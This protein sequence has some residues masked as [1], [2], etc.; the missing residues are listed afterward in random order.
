MSSLPALA[1]VLLG[2]T[3]GSTPQINPFPRPPLPEAALAEWKFD[4]GTEG[5]TPEHACRIS[6]ADGLL[7]VR[8]TGEDPY[9]HRPASLPGGDLVLRIRARSRT[10]G[11]GEIFW[12]TD[13]SPVRG[14]DKSR[15]FPLN[16][17]GRWHE[18]AVEFSAPGTLTDL[19]LDPGGGAGEFDI[20]WIRLARRRWH[21]LG[22]ERV[23][24]TPHAVRLAVKNYETSPCTITA[25]GRSYT[26]AGGATVAVERPV[27]GGSPLEV[28]GTEI[29]LQ[30][31]GIP[32]AEREKLPPLRRTVFL[33]HPEAAADWI[34]VPAG[35]CVLEVARDGSAARV[36]RGSQ[37]VAGLAPL[38]HCDGMV[39]RLSLV[40]QEPPV[41]F[42][43]AGIAVEIAVHGREFTV[44]IASAQPCEGPVV[45]VLGALKQGLFAGVEYLGAGEASSSKLD[46]ETDEHI[47]FAPDPL[48]V[49]MPLMGFVADRA[50]VAMTW[51]DMS[52]QPVYATPNF[53][54]G[55]GDH[56]MALRGKKIEATI[57][58]DRLP[59]EEVIAWAV[60]RH[61]LPPLPPAP[62][63]PDEQRQICLKALNGPLKS[64]A[65]WGHCA[66]PNWARHPYDGMASTIWRLESATS[67][68]GFLGATIPELPR[69]VPGGVHV[70]NES[71]YFVTGRAAQWKQLHV[72]QV[73]ALIRQQQPDASYR[74]DGPF[75]RGH[76]ENT[77]SGICAGPAMHLLE[78]A[79][80]TGDREALAAGCRTLDYM[81]RFDV[82]R[83]AQTWE[84][85]LHTPDLLA[86]AYSVW[87]YV[88]GYEVTGKKEYL[89]EARRWALSGIPF[90]Y[91]WSRYPI[92]LYSTPP[93][94]GATNWQYNWIGLPVQWVGG[95]YAYALTL[96]AP[97]DHSLDWSHLARGI[98]ISAEQQQYPDG[99]WVGLLPDSFVIR[100][101]TR[102]PARI[103]PCAIA[104][105]RMV[106]DG[107]LDSLAVAAAGK[108]RVAAP[109]P[110]TIRGGKAHVQAPAG[111]KYQ[112]LVDG[113]V[114]EVPAE[115]NGMVPL[116]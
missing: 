107:Q 67:G 9:F 29:R 18:Y 108:H 101:Q 103:N 52:L 97:H 79:W 68:R 37:V 8:N 47:R 110:V 73:Q 100:T 19:R 116:D 81:K 15:A 84:V 39:P 36:R 40:H 112:V 62:R 93:V 5:W 114:V 99:P 76:F 85:P 51:N 111:L 24:T 75:R 58:V 64:E 115:A 33:F 12:T 46:I 69:L 102:N 92:M 35:D 23:E 82:P 83:G 63:T 11:G 105:L 7:K 48:K 34:A 87:A 10:V 109:F 2:A 17:D 57:L 38:V 56:R 91:L 106:L 72:G 96:L 1:L 60:K 98:L 45:R 80:L 28:V 30:S 16:H 90:T 74:Y 113:K 50:S 43:G 71:I 86:S 25:S 78:Y 95:V 59:V 54:D 3:G 65:G 49:T 41:R 44:S 26:V 42:K 6:A 94:F 22:I 13:R 77:A 21:P 88:R 53:F 61:G 70:R 4:R 27:A 104:S 89:A 55:T 32:E 20:E 66:E 31:G 14:P